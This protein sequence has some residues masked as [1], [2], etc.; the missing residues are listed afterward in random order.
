MQPPSDPPLN[1]SEAD[2]AAAFA[3]DSTNPDDQ[4]QA[5]S[6]IVE[7]EA[8]SQRVHDYQ[9]VAVELAYHAPPRS[10]DAD[11]KSRL[12]DSLGLEQPADE[13]DIMDYL[14]WSMDALV[15]E[16]QA[17]DWSPLPSA[18][19]VLIAT[20]TTDLKTRTTAFFVK[21]EVHVTFPL[22]EHAEGEVIR[23]LTGD[24]VVLDQVFPAGSLIESEAGTSHQPSTQSGCLLFCV[25]SMDDKYI[26]SV[27]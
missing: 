22:H 25:S 27:I 14:S 18:P 19:E 23:V 26:D 10:L 4:I 15:Q 1:S 6:L 5:E 11:L 7:S 12:F 21:T 2:L 13:P 3:L 16:A 17:L 8:F 9:S 24:F 20:L